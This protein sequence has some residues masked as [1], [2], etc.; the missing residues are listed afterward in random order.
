MPKNALQKA[1]EGTIQKQNAT[2][3]PLS[4]RECKVMSVECKMF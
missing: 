2:H 3:I 4:L 1:F